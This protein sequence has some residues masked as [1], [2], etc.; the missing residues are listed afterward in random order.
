MLCSL[1]AVRVSCVRKTFHSVVAVHDVSFD[2]EAGE[3][4]GLLGP[5]G[6]GKTT[7]LRLIMDIFRPDS[8]TITVLGHHFDENDKKRIGYLPEE[9]GLYLRQTVQ[10][11]IEYLVE[12]KGIPKA[13]AR[14]NTLGWLERLGMMDAR[15]RRIQELSKGNQQKIQFIATVAADPEVL[16]LDEPFTGLDPIN[17]RDIIDAIQELS[18]RGK[19]I[20]LSTHQMSLVESLCR[21]VFMIH[22]GRQVLY[23]N[24][25]SIQQQH[26]D[27]SV[28]VRS[29]ANYNDSP[30]MTETLPNGRGT[31]ILLG[32][33]EC[34]RD[35][36]SWLVATGTEVES[37]EKTRIPLE[38]IFVKLAKSIPESQDRSANTR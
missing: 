16:I 36:L 11:V 30:W 12:L 10:S 26:S 38:D 21:R 20:I 2:I 5:N 7:L 28:T 19:T 15:T 18:L 27:H 37:F 14:A 33:R 17:T 32:D 8:G 22:R 1:P 35:V 23:G 13:R 3:I 4:F 25:E 31:K 6:A 29:N 24:I 34:T 9:R